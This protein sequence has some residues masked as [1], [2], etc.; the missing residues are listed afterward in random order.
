MSRRAVTRFTSDGTRHSSP[1]E[2]ILVEKV[3]MR[4]NADGKLVHI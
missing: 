1:T 4:S 3:I 2:Q